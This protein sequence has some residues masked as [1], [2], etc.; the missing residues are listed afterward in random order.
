M[1]NTDTAT[2]TTENGS[3]KRR[4]PIRM[5][6]ALAF[7]DEIPE[8]V[9]LS[10]G[11]G[12]DLTVFKVFVD[13]LESDHQN[14][15]A[16]IRFVDSDSAKQK[17]AQMR[18]LMV[19]GKYPVP[20]GWEWNVVARPI[21]DGGKSIGSELYFHTTKKL[22]KNAKGIAKTTDVVVKRTRKAKAKADEASS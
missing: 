12:Q 15:P 11:R 5:E 14:R 7:F 19:D 8:P 22:S 21:V 18:T 20:D 10:R 9:K 16:R 1:A 2:A 13:Y 17:A 6:T 4:V 3:A